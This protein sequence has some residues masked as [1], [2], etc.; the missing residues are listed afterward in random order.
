MLKVIAELERVWH[1]V[2]DGAGPELEKIKGAVAQEVGTLKDDV[3]ADL[4]AAKAEALAWVEQNAPQVQDMVG[5]LI[6]DIENAVKG[7]LAKH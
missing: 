1:E 4:A 3:H 6:T 5:K 2:M 7:A